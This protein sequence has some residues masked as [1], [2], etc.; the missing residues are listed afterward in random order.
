MSIKEE[1]IKS[2]KSMC[3]F[4]LTEEKL[5]NSPIEGDG[6]MNSMQIWIFVGQLEAK[7]NIKFTEEE[8]NVKTLKEIIEV[9]EKKR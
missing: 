5:I 4:N 8:L 6:L 3:K 7:F 9:I 1:V 2:F